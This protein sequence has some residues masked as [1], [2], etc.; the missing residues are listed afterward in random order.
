MPTSESPHL[1]PLPPER[2]DRFA[3][4]LCLLRD[5]VSDARA[6]ACDVWEFAVGI[7][8]LLAAGLRSTDLRWLLAHG[9]VEHAVE[10]PQPN[11]PRRQ[12]RQ[13]ANLSFT[14]L[15]SFVLTPT[16]EAVVRAWGERGEMM[17]PW[18][19]SPDTPGRQGNSLI[20]V[21][22]S[23]TRELF[24]GGQLVKCFRTP[25]ANQE[26][27]LT[28]FEEEGWPKRM[29]DPLTGSSGHD[30]KQRLHDAVNRLNRNQMNS[31]VRFFRDGTGQGICWAANGNGKKRHRRATRLPPE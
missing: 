29:D 1:P 22:D 18:A 28:V 2:Q 16:G 19:G 7:D 21:W 8:E 14:P 10:E 17:G 13:I 11:A 6:I 23:N 20:P 15:A 27:I 25:A 12:F 26:L 24:F 31:L 4:A 5:A 3:V 30:P 9:L